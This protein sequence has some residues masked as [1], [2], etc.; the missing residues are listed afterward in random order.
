MYIVFYYY[1]KYWGVTAKV[2]VV[3][4]MKEDYFPDVPKA[5]WPG[6]SIC[7]VQY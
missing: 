5:K 6:N 2:V 3:T 7:F 1:E 4:M